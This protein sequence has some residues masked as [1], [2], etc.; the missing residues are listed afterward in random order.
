[1]QENVEN[2]LPIYF[3]YGIQNVKIR[4]L[5]FTDKYNCSIEGT[6]HSTKTLKFRKIG[7]ASF[8]NRFQLYISIFSNGSI[9]QDGPLNTVLRSR[10]SIEWK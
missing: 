1:M 5:F 2:S 7:D 6:V 4:Y 10:L 3:N 9:M 8:G